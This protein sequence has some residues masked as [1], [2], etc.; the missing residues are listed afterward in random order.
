VNK[1][2]APYGVTISRAVETYVYV[3]VGGL[4]D[5]EWWR[6]WSYYIFAKVLQVKNTYLITEFYVDM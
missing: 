5:G 4:T 2:R 1:N 6:A 3:E